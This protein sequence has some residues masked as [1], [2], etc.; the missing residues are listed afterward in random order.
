M[1]FHHK[2]FIRDI[3]QWSLLSV[4]IGLF[5]A[6][7]G[8]AI[9]FYL[10][11]GPGE[12][13]G[14]I[15]SHFLLNYIGNS[16]FLIAG[17]GVLTFLI[18]TSAAWIVSSYDFPYRKLF[19]WLLFLPLA[20]PSYITAYA[21]V[22]LLGNGGT[23]VGFLQSIGIPI[24][25]IE[26]M[27]LYGLTWVLSIS[28]FPYVYAGTRA[29]F[30]SFP[31]VISDSA[32]LLGATRRTYFFKVAL[33]LASPAIIGGLFLVFMEVLNDYGA[34][35]YYGINTF[36]TGIFRTW[37][38]L[39]DLQSSIYLSALLV[40][41]VILI[42]L[43]VKWQRG[44]KSYT[45]KALNTGHSHSPRRPLSGRKKVLY[46]IIILLPVTFGFIL[47]VGQLLYWGIL[48]FESMFNA[49]LLWV[50]LQSFG[51]AFAAALI[52]IIGA[53]ALINVTKWNHLKGLGIF[54]KLATI[55]YVIPGAIIGIGVIRSSQTVITFFNDNF[56]MQV[57]YLFYGSSIILIYAYVFRFMA[58]AYNPIEAN[59]LKL[60]KNLSESAYLL[61]VS[62]L[63]AF[64]RIDFPLLKKTLLGAFF[65]VFI[66]ILK[67][68]P[69]TLILKP[70]NLQTLAINAYAYADDEQVA[71][72]ALPALLLITVIAILMLV[73]NHREFNTSEN[74]TLKN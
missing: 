11:D 63:K 22:G 5:I 44:R 58:V 17:T 59:T 61:G 71:K 49:E 72:A 47:P 36:T 60:S 4:A 25:R 24:K 29:M 28:L 19:D 2:H 34:A 1:R 45:I 38:A 53:L 6:I 51:V 55:G 27:N 56:D 66:D 50:T 14:H 43:F 37:T 65:L 31:R 3:N 15:V 70:Y 26:M 32:F 33:P 57:G 40:V 20:I 41:L 67:E 9:A 69:L 8:L 74:Q 12:M 64:R 13:W 73:V 30:A 68:L 54:S 7:P 16:L 18:G 10:F 23:L 62:K 21:Y 46:L 52:I 48:T 42:M 35:K 39:E